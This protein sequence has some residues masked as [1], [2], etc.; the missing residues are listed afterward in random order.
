MGLNYT[1]SVMLKY[2]WGNNAAKGLAAQKKAGQR[3]T[4]LQAMD[5]H[6][7]IRSN[8]AV[9]LEAVKR[10]SA[11]RKKAREAVA[12]YQKGVTDEATKYKMGMSTII[13]VITTAN[14]LDQAKL[15]EV[16][17]HLNYA[18]VVL[19]LR[20][21]TGTILIKE[22]DQYRVELNRLVQV[23]HPMAPFESGNLTK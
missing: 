8:V 12:L 16:T 2:P 3:Q 19:V 4:Q 7:T 9:A 21:E 13:N 5:L 23:P 14:C 6:R 22:K 17:N 10:H 20:F 15:T 1:A 11:G 18:N